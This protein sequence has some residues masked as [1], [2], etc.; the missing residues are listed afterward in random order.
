MEASRML[1][2]VNIGIFLTLA[3]V[4]YDATRLRA[5][6]INWTYETTIFTDAEGAG[7]GVPAHSFAANPGATYRGGGSFSTTSSDDP[8]SG[9]SQIELA[10]FITSAAGAPGEVGSHFLPSDTHFDL[11]LS[12]HDE[13]S[14]QSATLSFGGSVSGDINV[15]GEDIHFAFPDL[16]EQS[17]RLGNHIYTVQ[18]G[19]FREPSSDVL[20]NHDIDPFTG[21]D[22]QLVRSDLAG[23]IDATVTVE[24]APKA[25]E[26]ASLALAGFGLASVGLA[27]WRRRRA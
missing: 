24:D 1:K 7:G 8:I 19:P 13:A 9:S 17:V 15:T 20:F 6:V 14:G 18:F 23:L 3:I 26:P 2:C 21:V 10:T 22:T 16:T 25:P 5:D 11:S 27:R 4:A 12:L